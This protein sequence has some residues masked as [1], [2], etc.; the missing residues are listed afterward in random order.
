M[1]YLT[2][3]QLDYWLDQWAKWCRGGCGIAALGYPSHAIDQAFA[4]NNSRPGTQV[5]DNNIQCIVESAVSS[6][7]QQNRKAVEVGRFEYGASPRS[8]TPDYDKPNQER[9]ARQQGMSL[10]TYKRK[11]ADFKLAVHTTL[12]VSIGPLKLSAA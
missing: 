9:N 8:H 7:A 12:D 6:L 3:T 4:Q 2:D 5:F 1:S 11:L 10:A